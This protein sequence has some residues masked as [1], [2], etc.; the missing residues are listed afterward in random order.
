MEDYQLEILF[1]FTLFNINN[2][3]HDVQLKIFKLIKE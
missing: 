3:S 1:L 2:I